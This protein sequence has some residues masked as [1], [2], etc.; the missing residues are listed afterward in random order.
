MVERKRAHS[1]KPEWAYRM[2][3]KHFPN[4]PK[5]ELFARCARLGW[6]RWGAEAPPTAEAAE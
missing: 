5:V 1:V 6:D 3:E 2:I 4:V